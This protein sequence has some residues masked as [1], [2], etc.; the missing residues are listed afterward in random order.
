MKSRVL[1]FDY[2][3]KGNVLGGLE[4]L[5]NGLGLA[6]VAHGSVAVKLH[7][8]ELGNTAYLRPILP[9]RLLAWSRTPAAGP[10]LLI[11]RLTIPVGGVPWPGT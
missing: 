9:P 4:A 3:R 11:L 6:E 8:G 5:F 1:F 2:S 7:M 10:L